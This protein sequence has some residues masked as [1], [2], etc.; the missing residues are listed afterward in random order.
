MASEVQEAITSAIAE[1]AEEPRPR[2]CEKV[3]GTGFLRIRVGNY[4]VIYG[5]NDARQEVLVVRVGHRR[6]VYR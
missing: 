4:R 5:V 3:K 2:D 6:D 1:L